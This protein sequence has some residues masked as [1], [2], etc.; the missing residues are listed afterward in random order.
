MEEHF[1]MHMPVSQLRYL[2]NTKHFTNTQICCSKTTRKIQKQVGRHPNL[3][4][5]LPQPHHRGRAQ[6]KEI[7][8]PPS[9]TNKNEKQMKNVSQNKKRLPLK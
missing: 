2:P 5:P 3:R 7:I 9:G 6:L 4:Q 8:K 1:I